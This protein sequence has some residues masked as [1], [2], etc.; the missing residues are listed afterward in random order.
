MMGRDPENG[1]MVRE[2]QVRAGDCFICLPF[3]GVYMSQG[4]VHVG[5]IVARC[6][7]I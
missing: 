1:N 3:V 7:S 2:A 5:K 4:V 6:W